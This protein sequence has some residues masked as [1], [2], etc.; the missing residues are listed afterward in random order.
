MPRCVSTVQRATRRL[1]RM[2]ALD[3]EEQRRSALHGHATSAVIK[4]VCTTRLRLCLHGR[5]AEGLTYKDE[6]GWSDLLPDRCVLRVVCFGSVFWNVQRRRPPPPRVGGVRMKA[7]ANVS[8]SFLLVCA[9]SG[10]GRQI[11]KLPVGADESLWR[12]KRSKRGF[13]HCENRK[14]KP[15]SEI[16]GAISW[17]TSGLVDGSCGSR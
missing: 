12:V 13:P 5:D 2:L 17:P 8:P 9:R 15:Q 14:Q 1:Q 4:A 7:T 3:G 6:G 16:D 10:R 11:M